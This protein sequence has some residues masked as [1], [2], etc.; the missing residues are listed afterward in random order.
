M[1]KI[2]PP[3]NCEVEV[4]VFGPGYGEC[5][6]IHVGSNQWIVMDSCIGQNNEPVALTYLKDI[7]C[8]P[9]EC[10]RFVI[11]THWH[12]DHVQGIAK[13]LESAESATFVISTALGRKEF[14]GLLDAHE[15]LQTRIHYK[16]GTE[17]LASFKSRQFARHTRK[18]CT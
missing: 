2:E 9:G 7:G 16:G 3:N 13:V 18:V 1:S 11:A 17:M 12:D 10:V 6:L 8:N 5:I 14:L 15:R 4:T